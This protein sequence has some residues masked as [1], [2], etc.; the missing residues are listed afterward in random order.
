MGFPDSGEPGGRDVK[1]A[2]ATC[3]LVFAGNLV[4]LLCVGVPEVDVADVGLDDCVVLFFRFAVINPVPGIQ[5][6]DGTVTTRP[7][8]RYPLKENRRMTCKCH[9]LCRGS[10]LALILAL[11]L[12]VASPVSAASFI[13]G[14]RNASGAPEV[15]D[16]VRVFSCL[17]LGNPVELECEDA[18]DSD[19][20][21]VLDISDG[22]YALKFLF[23]G[24]ARPASPCPDCGE[25]PTTDGLDCA[26]F[27]RCVSLLPPRA[28][29]PA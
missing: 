17:F 7:A 29:S 11:T 27:S 8:L 26:V 28:K 14:D 6:H 9:D 1:R 18:A 22:I 24:G 23:T 21:G 4:D 13:R 3:V 20:S 25:N 19:D 15:T 12:T 5:V 2:N 16:P 10:A